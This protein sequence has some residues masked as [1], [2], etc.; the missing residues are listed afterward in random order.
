MELEKLFRFGAETAEFLFNKQ[1][2][3][4]PMWI[5]VNERGSKQPLLIPDFGDKDSAAEQ[6]REFL[7]RGKIIR[8]VSMLECWVYEGKDVPPEIL[9]GQSLEKNPDRREAIHI[10]AED[11]DDNTIS[12]RFYI[13][14]PEH[15]K[16][17][18][19]PLKTEELSG[20][21]TEGR[22]VKMFD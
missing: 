17:K 5:G 9:A 13:L 8:Y 4:V 11:R 6:V 3:L 22:F 2:F 19:S 7:R 21:R 12:G 20:G 10:L 14:R 1:G 18:L 15:D 16:P